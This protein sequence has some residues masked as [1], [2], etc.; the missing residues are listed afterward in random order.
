MT[1]SQEAVN[2]LVDIG[3]KKGFVTFGQIFNA[4]AA[5]K[6]DPTQLDKFLGI[7]EEHGIEIIDEDE[8][9]S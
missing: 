9:E 7:L 3:K 1:T 4:I 5:T 2:S 6:A 8:Q